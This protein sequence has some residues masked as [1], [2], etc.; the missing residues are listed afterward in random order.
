MDIHNTQSEHS[1][2]REFLSLSLND[3]GVSISLSGCFLGQETI[4]HKAEKIWGLR[5]MM[6]RGMVS[7]KR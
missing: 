6:K 7:Q 2:Y 1:A 3:I 5:E 4:F